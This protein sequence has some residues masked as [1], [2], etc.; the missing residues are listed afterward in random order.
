MIDFD[1]TGV[2]T[3]RTPIHISHADVPEGE[4]GTPMTTIR[5]EGGLQPVPHIPGSTIKGLLRSAC[6]GVA[7]RN[8]RMPMEVY[9]ILFKGGIKGDEKEKTDDLRRN[10]EFRAAAP[11]LGL[12]GAASPQWVPGAL[13]I[14]PAQPTSLEDFS[15]VHL[16][17]ARR[18]MFRQ[19]PEEFSV[20]DDEGVEDYFKYADAMKAV[21][22]ANGEIEDL[23]RR[24]MKAKR[25]TDGTGES[26]ADLNAAIKEV[27][28]RRDLSKSSENYSNAIGR[29]LPQ[30]R[31]I[32][33][34]SR[35]DQSICGRGV[36]D[37]EFG[38]L[39]EGLRA[40]SN[41]C[42]IG[43]LASSGMGYFD[44]T[45]RLRVKE[46]AVDDWE[47]AGSVSLSPEGFVLS[48][49]HPI[50]TRAQAAWKGF[51]DDSV[52]RIVP[53]TRATEAKAKAAKAE[54]KSAKGA[55]G[56]SEEAA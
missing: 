23:R 51:G 22:Q 28:K 37:V 19:N 52:D 31:M 43:G 14:L 17:G 29:P 54:A 21:S 8:K 35:F 45:W 27:E 4:L 56:S 53:F 46:A 3:A 24:I 50:V 38:L 48:S 32:G 30:K 5:N 20:L 25:T 6:G 7:A 34:G 47:D 1:L 41:K 16:G 10:A 44:A 40:L 12:F 33:P 39:L 36:H 55:K 18:D 42:R 9:N 26:V 2:I 49:E 13:S 11:L 15:I